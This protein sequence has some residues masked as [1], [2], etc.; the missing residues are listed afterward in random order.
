MS[1]RRLCF[2]FG[3]DFTCEIAVAEAVDAVRVLLRFVD[4]D[5]FGFPLENLQILI[6]R[7]VCH[8]SGRFFCCVLYIAAVLAKAIALCDHLS[9]F[10]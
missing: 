4:D 2:F 8:T 3:F 9:E 7:G 6:N 1:F 5:I 10:G